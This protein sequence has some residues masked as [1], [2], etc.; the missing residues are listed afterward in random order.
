MKILWALALTASGAAAAPYHSPVDMPRY[1]HCLDLAATAPDE[2]L[3]YANGWRATGGGVPARHCLG[4]SYLTKKQYAAAAATLEAAARAGEAEQEPLTA[5]LWAQA[6]NAAML[7]N[8]PDRAMVFFNS[9]LAAAGDNKALQA[10]LLIDRARAAVELGQIAA[11]QADLAK[12]VVANPGSA[13]AWL[14]TAT[15]ERSAGDYDKAEAAILKAAGLAVGDVDVAVEAGNIAFAQGH[16]KLAREAWA[17]VVK[18]GAGSVA[19]EIAAKA[20]AAYP[21]VP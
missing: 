10:D 6:G 19:A 18:V 15:L 3:A 21:E 9:G 11:A 20:L 7:G 5:S 4:L 8:T 12:A 14:L 16:V 1:R 13:D 17:A 2:A